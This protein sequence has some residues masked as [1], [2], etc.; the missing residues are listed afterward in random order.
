M[1]VIFCK[2]GWR[3]TAYLNALLELPSRRNLY[4]P[5]AMDRGWKHFYM[6]QLPGGVSMAIKIPSR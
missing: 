5:G 2:K 3:Y 6:R 4:V 1:E